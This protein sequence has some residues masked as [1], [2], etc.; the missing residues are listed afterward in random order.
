MDSSGSFMKEVIPELNKLCTDN[1][2]PKMK[3]KV[4]CHR[5]VLQKMQI[6]WSP[7]NPKRRLWSCPFYSAKKCNLFEWRGDLI[8]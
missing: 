2:D 8:D 6:S 5:G 4:Q 7:N 1:E 3:L